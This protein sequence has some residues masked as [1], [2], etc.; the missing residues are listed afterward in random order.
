MKTLKDRIALALYP[1][2]RF[3]MRKFPAPCKDRAWKA[4]RH[5]IGWRHSRRTIRSNH[6]FL[7]T[8][9]VSQFFYQCL[10]FLGCWEPCITRF[11]TDRLKPGDC[12]ID[13]GANIGYHSL[14]SSFLVGETGRVVAVEASPGIY[15]DLIK[16]LQLNGVTNVRT[17]NVAASES[18]GEI[19]L[20]EAPEDCREVTTTSPTWAKQYGCKLTGKVPSLP[21]KMVVS[22]EEL[23][24]ARIIKIDVEGAEWN[25]CEGLLPALLELRS[26]AEIILEVTPSE[27]ESQGRQCSELIQRFTDIGFFPYV[28]DN[29]RSHEFLAKPLLDHP[30]Q[31]LRDFH[32]T[33]QTD[34]V[35]SRTNAS[36]L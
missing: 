36:H 26:D 4:I 7:I 30:P 22:K 12:F 8:G 16:N 25:V 33:E 17:V 20:F 31:R 11:V 29:S 2:A 5:H 19:D 21:R 27:I 32:L 14:L 15:A 1:L 6:G 28:I 23:R 24:T 18:P 34:L 9:D 13:V 10:Y 35:F 3:Y